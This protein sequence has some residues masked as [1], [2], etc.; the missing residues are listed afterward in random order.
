M[1]DGKRVDEGCLT[2]R[3]GGYS[4][5]VQTVQCA[6]ERRRRRFTVAREVLHCSGQMSAAHQ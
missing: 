5:R 3:R 6:N 2:R 4:R 1:G